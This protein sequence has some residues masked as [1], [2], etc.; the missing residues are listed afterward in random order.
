MSPHYI[1]NLLKKKEYQV[2]INDYCV[3]G[4]RANLKIEWLSKIKYNP[5]TQNENETFFS[6]GKQLDNAHKKYIE[7]LTQINTI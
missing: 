1:V 3:G 2:I 4:A 6:L 7:L 5:P